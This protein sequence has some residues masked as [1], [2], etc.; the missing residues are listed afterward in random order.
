M[1][2]EKTMSTLQEFLNEQEM[3]YHYALNDIK[4]AINKH[5]SAIVLVALM[6]SALTTHPSSDTMTVQ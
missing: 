5:G 4:D 2:E 1:N 3:S 6:E